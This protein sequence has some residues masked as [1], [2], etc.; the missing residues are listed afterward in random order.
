MKGG[1]C[2]RGTIWSCISYWKR[3]D[4]IAM[5]VYWMGPI[6]VVLLTSPKV[7]SQGANR[8]WGVAQY[9]ACAKG[10]KGDL[11]CRTIGIERCLTFFAG[12]YTKKA[13]FGQPCAHSINKFFSCLGFFPWNFPPVPPFSSNALSSRQL[14]GKVQSCAPLW[15]NKMMVLECQGFAAFCRCTV[16]ICQ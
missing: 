8:C 2:K 16:Y 1:C 5:L 10:I 4:S 14:D 3:W 7:C 9:V 13:Q 15:G 6:P 11:T 12:P